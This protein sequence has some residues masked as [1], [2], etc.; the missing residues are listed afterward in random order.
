MSANHIEH[1]EMLKVLQREKQSFG[2]AANEPRTL[3]DFLEKISVFKSQAQCLNRIS[4]Q[5][6]YHIKQTEQ[7]MSTHIA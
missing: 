7:T 6:G 1:I 4:Q 5:T 3:L 2:V